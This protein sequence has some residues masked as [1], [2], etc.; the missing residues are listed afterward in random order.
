MALF[1]AFIPLRS[2]RTG[3]LSEFSLSPDYG[4]SIGGA[5]QR[6][7]LNLPSSGICQPF[8]TVGGRSPETG[9]R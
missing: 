2:F 3:F 5:A 7:E 1:V 8:C 9:R 6:C 4:D